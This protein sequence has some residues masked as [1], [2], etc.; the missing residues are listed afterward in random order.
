MKYLALGFILLNFGNS[1]YSKVWIV[2]LLFF[3][4]CNNCFAQQ[5]YENTVF[6]FEIPADH[7]IINNETLI[8]YNVLQN[9]KEWNKN[10]FGIT[11]KLNYN[12]FFQI[13]EVNRRI[14][15]LEEFNEIFLSQENIEFALKNGLKVL[16]NK[17][18]ERK[19][20]ILNISHNTI[21]DEYIHT[22][23]FVNKIGFVSIKLFAVERLS[24][25][26]LVFIIDGFHH[27]AKYIGFP[28][29]NFFHGLDWDEIFMD[30]II[31][32]TT[33]GK[34]KKPKSKSIRSK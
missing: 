10:I 20:L 32:T 29:Y 28:T 31:S 17:I 23:N 4:S 6:K 1:I 21:Y 34:V 8:E 13:I 24:V 27:Q 26:E 30:A 33:G 5:I 3:I 22:C 7:E 9:K 14:K 2:L 18:I 19:N 25:E 16:D 11:D 15:D 12:I